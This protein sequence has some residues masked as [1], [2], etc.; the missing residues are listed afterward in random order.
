MARATLRKPRTR[1][2]KSRSSDNTKRTVQYAS[3]AS[4]CPNPH[5]ARRH[6][7]KQL[8]L[9]CRSIEEFGFNVP[10]LID[11]EGNILAGHGRFE[12][13]KRLGLE[14][15]PVICLAHLSESER[16]AF[17]LAD[18]RIAE[19][20]HWDEN[21]LALELQSILELDQDLDITVTG[22]DT[23]DID[24]AIQSLEPD[25][26]DD[27]DDEVPELAAKPISQ[28]GDLWHCGVHR[29]FCGDATQL[30]N[31]RRLVGRTKIRQ[32]VIDP[33]YN[34]AVQGHV[35]GLGRTQHREFV[36]AS[37]E[38]SWDDFEIFLLTVFRNITMLAADGCLV[39]CFMNWRGLRSLL[40]AGYATFNE[41][42]NLIVWSKT[43]GAMGSFYRSQH[44]LITVWKHGKGP[45]INNFELGSRRYR[46]N[47]W[48]YPGLNTFKR[49]R[50]EELSIHPTCKPVALIADAL[51]DCSN[52]GDAVLDLFAGSGTIFLAAEKTGRRAYAMELDPLY[53]D[54]AVKRWQEHTGEAAV[55]AETGQTFEEVEETRHDR[56]S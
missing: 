44:E 3:I 49:G 30:K 51:L 12:A 1:H 4:L 18:N 28:P 48:T 39:F 52:R 45:H 10:L 36:M 27:P 8:E 41:L 20:S 56:R 40:P 55:L 2:S 37:G 19:L 43:N 42:K 35:S 25:P 24:L 22:F 47:V 33:P 7:R 32:V 31:C 29:L 46:T 9:I 38:M 26:P 17:M 14:T 15:V 11:G 16:R 53:C 21:A 54:V 13:A 5:N 6:G 50:M 23:A 34:V